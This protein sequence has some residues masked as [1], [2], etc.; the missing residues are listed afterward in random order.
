MFDTTNYY[1]VMASD[2][3]SELTQRGKSKEGRNWLRQVGVALL[4]SRDKRIP[5]Y[6]REYEG[7]RHDSKVFL[8]VMEDLFSAMR[9]SVG[10]DAVLT[11][12]F[13]KGMNSEDNIAAIDSRE[14]VNFITTYSPYFA[15]HLVHVGLDNFTVVATRKNQK[16]ARE[17]RKYDRLLAWRI[18]G[19]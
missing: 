3:E 7:N 5:L 19:E 2:T 13:D 1:T 15:E 4:V 6:Y 14:Y 12:V 9:D 17:G 11:V 8:Q 18:Q 10:E 16:L